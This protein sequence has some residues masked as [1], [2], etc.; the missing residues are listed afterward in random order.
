VR[1]LNLV[2][3]VLPSAYAAKAR[4]VVLCAITAGAAYVYYL[5]VDADDA[6]PPA[7]ADSIPA[8][9]VVRAAS[10]TQ[11][12]HIISD[13]AAREIAAAPGPD[14]AKVA[15]DLQ[16][17]LTRAHCYDGPINGK[18]T[19]ASKEAMDAFLVSVN[20]QLP[21][22]DPDPAL[23]ALIASNANAT[24]PSKTS[25]VADAVN[26]PV[27]HATEKQ[28]QPRV[29]IAAET[30]SSISASE[31]PS[32]PVDERSML[33]HPWAQPEMLVPSREMTP[34]A[35][36]AAQ[37]AVSGTEPAKRDITQAPVASAMASPASTVMRVSTAASGDSL[38]H[39]E[40]GSVVSDTKPEIAPSPPAMAAPAKVTQRKSKS[41]KRRAS[42]SNDSAFGVSFDSIQRSLSSLFD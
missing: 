39:F 27:P 37:I 35:A 30:P 7:A 32:A 10:I 31:A 42:R 34:P 29:A 19:A 36:A 12:I 2:R 5:A 14:R 28:E 40:G 3:S 6:I 8:P 25:V 9:P 17:A 23:L 26:A 11:P 38:L 33:D 13:A 1:I 41:A 18:W 4:G 24:C 22:G 15:R 16:T 20:A 21:V